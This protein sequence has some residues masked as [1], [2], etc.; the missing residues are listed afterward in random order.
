V[1]E[2]GAPQRDGRS[3]IEQDT[4]SG[5]GECAAGSMLQYGTHL[6]QGHTRKPLHELIHRAPVFEILEKRRH[7]YA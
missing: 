4:H 3:L 5:R 2:Q 7:G 6:R 1:N